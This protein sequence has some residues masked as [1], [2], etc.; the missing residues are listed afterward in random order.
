MRPTDK[1]GTFSNTSGAVEVAAE[2]E[3][4]VP[5]VDEPTIDEVGG[6]MDDLTTV[7]EDCEVVEAALF[8]AETVKKRI[9]AK[10][11][12]KIRRYAIAKG[13]TGG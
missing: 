9:Q 1:V 7:G 4:R 11:A 12:R 13:A 3:V 6:A 8:C 10:R 2:E 5:A